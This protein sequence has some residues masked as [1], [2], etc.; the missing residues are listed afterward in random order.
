MPVKPVPD[1]YNTVTPYL[2]IKGVERFTTFM[3]DVFSATITEQ[4]TQPDGSI[5]HTELR[6]G[7]SL[8]MLSE[9][10]EDRP[11]M[12]T[13]LH[14]Y[15]ENVDETFDRAIKAGARAISAPADQFYGDRSAGVVEPCG[16]TLWI[17]T[18][19]EDVPPAEL[20]RRAKARH[21]A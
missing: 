8:I 3:A 12:P 14:L 15:I 5:G 17:A 19:I 2:M 1:G 7:D 16:N 20:K 10:S 13:M 6:I 18:H 9:A 21:K 4:L 11:A